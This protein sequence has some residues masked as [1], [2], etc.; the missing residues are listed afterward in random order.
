[1]VFSGRAIES[2]SQHGE[3]SGI[4]V[5]PD[6]TGHS[7]NGVIKRNSAGEGEIQKKSRRQIEKS[8]QAGN[9]QD[10]PVVDPDIEP[11]ESRRTSSDTQFPATNRLLNHESTPPRELPSAQPHSEEQIDEADPGPGANSD[12]YESDQEQEG[13]PLEESSLAAEPSSRP[14][15][16]GSVAA[17]I[18]NVVRGAAGRA[19]S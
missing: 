6:E 12:I 11:T 16:I 10:T 15:L 4:A 8:P 3:S 7:V 5:D 9:R 1:M 14:G 13:P 17:S 19:P 18:G 2:Q